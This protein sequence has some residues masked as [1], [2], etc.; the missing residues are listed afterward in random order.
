MG[1]NKLPELIIFIG[2]VGSGK[3]TL[4]AKFAKK[5]YVVV[6]MDSI[7]AMIG[8]GEYGLYD[9]D[10]REIYHNTEETMIRSA[11][12]NG[13][14]VVVDRT[15]MSAAKRARYIVLGKKYTDKIVAYDWGPGD[16]LE[17]RMRDSRGIPF[18]TWCAVYAR[19][20]ESYEAPTMEEG[21]TDV[22]E[23]P[24]SFM[25]HAFDF[26]GTIVKNRF[27]MIGAVIPEQ[28]RVI[29]ELWQHNSNIII[30]WSCRSGDYQ[31]RMKEFLLKN[32]IPFDFINENPIYNFGGPKVFAHMYYD[33][34]AV[35]T[36]L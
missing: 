18:D 11:L 20:A 27:P 13:F 9:Y 23:A 10:K 29:E 15:N 3:S 17:R 8:G 16:D 28:V 19:M 31:D 7:T 21:F 22:V 25:C 4:A 24:K 32:K 36:I 33:D 35:N 14:S 12:Q 2:N 1:G 26:D 30:I 5:G 34:R 6:N